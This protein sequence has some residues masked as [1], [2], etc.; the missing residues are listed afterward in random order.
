[1][2]NKAKI[3]ILFSALLITLISCSV[4][5]YAQSDTSQLHYEFNASSADYCG[6][7]G[8]NF[9]GYSYGYQ[10]PSEWA[11]HGTLPYYND[12]GGYLA[13]S[14]TVNDEAGTLSSGSYDS[15]T[16]VSVNG[17]YGGSI[18]FTTQRF[19][20]G[21]LSFRANGTI[22]GRSGANG[23]LCT[24]NFDAT[25]YSAVSGGGYFN[26]KTKTDFSY[27]FKNSQSNLFLAV[28]DSLDYTVATQEA[29]FNKRSKRFWTLSDINSTGLYSFVNNSTG[30]PLFSD[31]ISGNSQVYQLSG[32]NRGW[33]F[34]SVGDGTSFYI[35]YQYNNRNGDPSYAMEPSGGSNQ[36]GAVIEAPTKADRQ[37]QKWIMNTI[38]Q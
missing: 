29:Y 14:W 25:T 19:P 18:D 4:N 34:V 26:L 38:S 28:P 7:G 35:V 33:R 37:S 3:H 15:R 23:T 2:K 27:T 20:I 17:T 22:N 30:K 21:E 9:F 1:M 11:V 32:S 5:L 8:I 24:Q 6:A 10:S 36:V 12:P 13:Y 31:F 16:G